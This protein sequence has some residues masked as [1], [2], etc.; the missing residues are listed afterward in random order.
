MTNE[1]S[2]SRRIW[3]YKYPIDMRNQIDGLCRI[4]AENMNMNP[5]NGD[6]FV[7]FSF[8]ADRAKL[9][10]WDTTGFVMVYKRLEYGSFAVPQYIGKHLSISPRE[11]KTLL[12][13]VVDEHELHPSL[14]FHDYY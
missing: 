8:R 3:V 13:G 7:F 4:V 11:L 2:K 6:I 5:Q 1:I 12:H 10:F 14:R 9:L